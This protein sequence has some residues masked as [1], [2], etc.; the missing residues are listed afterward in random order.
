VTAKGTSDSRPKFQV[1][2][3]IILVS[4]AVLVSLLALRQYSV[5]KKF[6]NPI[7]YTVMGDTLYVVEKKNNTVLKFDNFSEERPLLLNDRF[8]IEGDD[9][10][11]YYMLRRLYPGPN[12]VVVRSFVYEKKGGN[13]VGYRFREYPTFKRPPK[14]IF[15]I[16]LKD[17]KRYPDINY[18]FDK[19]GCHYFLNNCKGQ[20]NIWKLPKTGNIKM[21]KGVV[22][23][24]ILE[25]G[26]LNET[27]SYWGAISVD[28]DG[29]IFASPSVTGRV[30]AYSRDGRRVH[31]IGSVGFQKGELL[32]PIDLS[33]IRM[34][35]QEPA[36]LTIASTGNRTWVQ[37][38]SQGNP[39]RTISPLKN[40]YQ[41]PDILVGKVYQ[42]KGGGHVWSFD[43]P[44]KC[45]VALDRDFMAVTTY[46][47]REPGKTAL[48]FGLAV[49]LLLLGVFFN[50]IVPFLKR[51]K[52]P[53]ILKLMALVVPL[54]IISTLLVGE[55]VKD[56][57]KTDLE[58]EVVRRSANLAQAILNSISVSDLEKITSPKDRGSPAYDRIYDTVTRIVDLKKVEYTP[59][60]IIH[61]IR[62]GF[63]Y[64]GINIWRGPIFEPFIVP[65]DRTM[66]FKVLEQKTYQS[67]RFFDEQ[68]EWFSYLWPILNSRGDVIYVLELYRPTE[69]MD[70]AEKKALQRVRKIG[71]ITVITAALLLVILFLYVFNRPLR[72][73]IQGTEIVKTGNFD[74]RIEVH[75]RDE[76]GTLASAFNEMVIVLKKYT[77]DL[78]QATAARERIENELKIAHDIQMGMLPRVFPPFPHRNEFDIHAALIP[79][80]EVGGDFYDF[81]LVDEDQICF[82]VGDVS[83][84][85]VPAALFM[86]MTKT[87]IKAKVTKGLAPDK[88]LCRVNEDLS[89][90][91]PS[92]MFVTLFLGILNVRT[93]ELEYSNAAHN[94]PYIIRAD[95]NARSL[96]VPDGTPLGVEEDFSYECRRTV[97]RKGD[98]IFLYTDGVTEAMDHRRQLFTEERLETAINSLREK[99]NEEL[100]AGIMKEIEAFSKGELQADD[101]TMMALS[102]HG[103]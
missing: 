32:A 48:L 97:L 65:R 94:A 89:V 26:D 41:F 52:F 90:D 34:G 83:G 1:T 96:E 50:R 72:K 66:F 93:G 57:M 86:A 23:A 98:T 58:A 54:L 29:R 21:A 43:L 100:I 51:L 31:E 68:G 75:S 8:S 2:V 35:T 3:S 6:H 27:Y 71:T 88:V 42:S 74:H 99:S 9:D 13:F 28:A 40:G 56:I 55:W 45:L 4:I 101:I 38:N 19:E 61:K 47:A 46:V 10:K 30:V 77:Q 7:A 81:F 76:L 82:T 60:W 44:N 73:F 102:Y 87:L 53:F 85:G 49:A 36:Y 20:H 64:F 92:V 15:T 25:L 16:Y 91:N 67:G 63:F 80:K 79:A 33:N 18:A 24:G 5:E 11:Y 39:V 14:E 95:G 17:P 70:R 84:K 37:L 22:P 103:H 12:G 62:D 59:R 69:E 78:A